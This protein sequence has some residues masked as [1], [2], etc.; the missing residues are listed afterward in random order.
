MNKKVFAIIIALLVITL[1]IFAKKSPDTPNGGTQ[2]TPTNSDQLP[3][4]ST[5]STNSNQVTVTVTTS[6]F[7]PETVTIKAGE[8]VVWVNQSGAVSNVSSAKHPTHLIYPPLNLGDFGNGAS[9][10]LSFDKPGTY[11]YHNHL[12][13]TEVGTVV[14]E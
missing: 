4:N 9:V 1:F 13:P 12:N 7:Q 8:K 10:S 11:T 5:N 2:P 14:V 6:G 3:T